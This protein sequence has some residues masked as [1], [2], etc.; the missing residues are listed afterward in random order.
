MGTRLLNGLSLGVV[1]TYIIFIK[2]NYCFPL[3]FN[4][5]QHTCVSYLA[6]IVYY[7]C[8]TYHFHKTLFRIIHIQINVKSI[9]L[10]KERALINIFDSKCQAALVL[11]V[12]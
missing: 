7:V 4:H 11:I 12:L 3:D 9:L 10:A 1:E 6:I 5:F 8:Y 2:H